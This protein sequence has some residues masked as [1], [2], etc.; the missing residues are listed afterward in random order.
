VR[1]TRPFVV[2]V[3]SLLIA[4]TAPALI[5]PDQAGATLNPRLLDSPATWFF[6]GDSM[7]YSR[8]D[9]ARLSERLGATARMVAMGGSSPPHWY[10]ALKNV[11]AQLSPAPQRVFIFFR[12]RQLTETFSSVDGVQRSNLRSLS[13]ADEPELAR[14]LAANRDVPGRVA[15]WLRL[16]YPV[17]AE[18]DRA[19]EYIG[20]LAATP[21][22]SGSWRLMAGA[23]GGDPLDPS[24]LERLRL[25]REATRT[26]ANLPFADQHLRKG[27]AAPGPSIERPAF[28]EE[29]PRSFLPAMLDLADRHQLRLVFVRVRTRVAADTRE[30]A[31]L[32]DLRQHLEGR[33]ATYLDMTAHP[34]V[35]PDWF[36]EGDHIAPARLADYTDYFFKVAR[37]TLGGVNDLPE[38]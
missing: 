31:Y 16:V 9:P 27:P 36:G 24:E 19:R 1:V 26:T 28:T 33:G 30:V 21:L 7:L 8:I 4:V 11:A 34:G 3:A 17:V 14:I 23:L 13:H 25:A 22:A 12:G 20:L 35:T 5:R 15:E 2:L 18:S 37:S 32:F 29:F 6:V 38:H 10:L